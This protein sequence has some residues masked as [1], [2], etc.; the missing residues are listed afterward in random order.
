MGYSTTLTARSGQYGSANVN[1]FDY[2]INSFKTTEIIPRIHSFILSATNG[3]KYWLNGGTNPDKSSNDLSTL[4]NFSGY[5]GV[6]E[7]GSINAHFY[8]GDIAEIIIF[9]RELNDRERVD[10]EKY[11]SNKF[12]IPLS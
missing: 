8:S 10:I 9:S 3:K 2:A 7:Y 12:N 4:T 1:F 5:V 11:L 6:T